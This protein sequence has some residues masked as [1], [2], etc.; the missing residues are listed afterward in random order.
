[1]PRGGDRRRI[2]RSKGRYL[3]FAS[4]LVRAMCEDTSEAGIR[5]NREREALFRRR[6]RLL[7]VLTRYPVSGWGE[8]PSALD[9]MEEYLL[10]VQQGR[11]VYYP[12]PRPLT[13]E[14]QAH[15]RCRWDV[16][17]ASLIDIHG[18]LRAYLEAGD[19][20]ATQ[21]WEDAC[22][23][24]YR[25]AGEVS[26]AANPGRRTRT[27]KREMVKMY[28]KELVHFFQRWRLNAWWAVP[29]FVQSHF[30]RVETGYGGVLDSYVGGF[31]RK[32]TFTVSVK[33]SGASEED[34]Q[35]DRQR[36]VNAMLEGM[37]EPGSRPVTVKRRLNR[38]EMADLER[39]H[40]ASCMV[41][42]WDARNHYQSRHSPHRWVTVSEYIVEECEAHLGRKLPKRERRDLVNQVDPQ[43]T[44]GRK[45]FLQSGWD[46]HGNADLAL[47]ANWVTQ[48]LLDPDRSWA[49]ISGADADLLPSVMRACRRFA[50]HAGLKLSNGRP[51][52]RKRPS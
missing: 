48:R 4:L 5:F 16:A 30:S 51:S 50:Q 31:L 29:A 17:D 22:N 28:R 18:E 26:R 33:L 45:W 11:V 14:E 46:V 37:A 2:I 1:M 47:H 52:P 20:R 23:Y 49:A 21:I 10:M 6:E 8:P 44:A 7:R 15:D 32:S 43:L 38:A 40:S 34:F 41:I 42:D 24:L 36:F 27:S 35:G 19:E 25:W 13:Q 12:K 39:Q 3:D 9:R